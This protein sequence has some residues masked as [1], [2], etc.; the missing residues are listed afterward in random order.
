MMISSYVLLI[1]WI[2]VQKGLSRLVSVSHVGDVLGSSTELVKDSE[3]KERIV[4]LL[5][6]A[7]TGAGTMESISI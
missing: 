1:R 5:M 2:R 7:I 4:Y 3:R 6:V